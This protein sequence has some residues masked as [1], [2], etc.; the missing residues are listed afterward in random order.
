MLLAIALL[1]AFLTGKRVIVDGRS[2][3][4][5]LLPD[6]QA[7]F[8][9]EAYRKAGPQRG[10][11]VLA[12]HPARPEMLLIKRVAGAP[13][14]AVTNDETGC[15]INSAWAAETEGLG[16][17]ARQGEWTLGNDEYFLLGDQPVHSTDSRH[18]G[19]VNRRSILG[20]GW[21]VYWPPRRARWLRKAHDN[22]NLQIHT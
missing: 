22:S 1:F 2:M 15:W 11:I 9:R 20:R 6:E 8:D 13:G 3:Y 4:P 7:L 19:P 5:T 14:D 18:F 17:P 16:G 10:D 12:R 21:L